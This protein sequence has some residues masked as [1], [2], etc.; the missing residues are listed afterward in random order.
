MSLRFGQ[1]KYL[2]FDGTTRMKRLNSII[3]RTLHDISSHALEFRSF[4]LAAIQAEF[5]LN[6][7][8]TIKPQSER[9]EKRRLA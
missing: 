3:F 1:A 6:R 7:Y 5:A 4:V 2:T 9:V 8:C